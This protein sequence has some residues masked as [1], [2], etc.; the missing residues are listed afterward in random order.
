[1][2]KRYVDIGV[3]VPSL[4]SVMD[5]S[6]NLDQAVSEPEGTDGNLSSKALPGPLE[7]EAI[8]PIFKL[9]YWDEDQPLTQVCRTLESEYGFVARSVTLTQPRSRRRF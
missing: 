8:R 2:V 7:W 3:T 6:V 5:Q 1:M 4:P 9:L